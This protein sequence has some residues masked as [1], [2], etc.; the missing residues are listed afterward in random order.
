MVLT[1]FRHSMRSAMIATLSAIGAA[2]IGSAGCNLLRRS[3][4]SPDPSAT[5]G[6]APQT[7]QARRV[8]EQTTQGAP[9]S[10]EA[11]RGRASLLLN[12]EVSDA[13]KTLAGAD[14]ARLP[15]YSDLQKL[16]ESDRSF[17]I[18]AFRREPLTNRM[19]L[20]WG[21]AYLGGDEVRQVFTDALGANYSG[22]KFDFPELNGLGE[23]LRG[24]GY[25]AQKDPVAFNYLLE[26]VDAETWKKNRT[27][28]PARENMAPDEFLTG[29]TIAGLGRSG[30]P[31][32]RDVLESLATRD[33]ATIKTYTGAIVDSMF[34]LSYI[35]EHGLGPPSLELFL[36][37]L[38]E[39][40]WERWKKSEEGRYWNNWYRK[41]HGLEP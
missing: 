29:F 12:V 30:N 5:L 40:E 15:A 33:P 27:W 10:N 16:R 34:Y 41:V 21:L 20:V 6:T 3:E 35:G 13:A 32:A 17:L 9:D 23:I 39:A 2:G 22:Q 28:R 19:G 24:L 31:R 38:R 18:K 26:R 11:R 8:P 1:E 7:L 14:K 4:S 37:H 25:L 36:P